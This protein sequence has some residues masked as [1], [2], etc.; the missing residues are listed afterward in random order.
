VTLH[1]H[2]ADGV[3]VLTASRRLAHA[4]RI[5]YATHARQQGMTAW[6][7]PVVLPWTT[8][9]RQQWLDFRARDPAA[10]PTRLLSPAQARLLWEQILA[11][12]P[13]AHDLLNPAEAARTAQRS[14][15]RMH[16]YSIDR[17]AL[18]RFET[19]EARAL[20]AWSQEF[21]R[22]CAAMNAVDEA[23]LAHWA[24]TAELTPAQPLA[25]VGFDLYAPAL[26]RLIAR[27][28][29][30]GLIRS[31][32]QPQAHAAHID[33][34]GA[35]DREAEVELAARWARAQVEAG[36]QSIAVVMADL[37]SRHDEV[38][39]RFEEVFAPT[40]RALN[41]ELAAPPFIIAAP[42]PLSQF[43]IAEGALLFLQLLQGHANSRLAGRLL[44]SPF[45]HAAQQERDARALADARLR[46]EQRDRWDV[47]EFERWAAVTQCK[48]LEL[49]AREVVRLHR[50][51]P[52]RAA[53]SAWAERFHAL[54]RAIGWPGERTL[55]SVEQQTMVKFQAC[56]AEL[57]SLD[58]VVGKVA[59]ADALHELVRLAID[60]LFEPETP[61]AWVTLIDPTTIA[62]MSFDALW[63]AGLDAARLPA[64]SNPDPLI[65]VELQRAAGIPEASA[66]T[67]FA[68]SRRRLQRLLTSANAVVLSWPQTEGDA[69]LQMSPL[70]ADLPQSTIEQVP[71]ADTRPWQRAMFDS[72]P[73]LERAVDDLAPAFAE[74]SARGGARILELQSQCAFRAQAVLRL[75]AQPLERVTS[76]IKASDRGILLH[77][78]LAALWRELGDQQR[79]LAFSPAALEQRLHE[80]AQL[81]AAQAIPAT[82]RPRA[83]LAQL[84]ITNVVQQILRLLE[85]DRRRPPFVIRR[86]ERDE[87]YTIGG[88]ELRLQLDRI[89]QLADGCFVI[90]YKLGDSHQP[91]Q[92]LDTFPGRPRQPQLPLY[93]LA[94]AEELTGLAF[95]ILAPGSVGYRGW[96]NG[97]TVAPGIYG[98]PTGMRRTQDMPG[99]WTLLVQ[100]WREVLN[101]LAQQYV[102]GDAAVDP[103]PQA[104]TYCHLST[105]CR[106]HERAPADEDAELVDD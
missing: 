55:S 81:Q 101:G 28:D 38:Q 8:W 42:Q 23:Q 47:Y 69:E 35:Q 75:S 84:E 90:D 36:R 77:R 56:L 89:D 93:A 16:E 58:A 39:R 53:P 7:T 22:R 34:V 40:S 20:A 63:V 82:T 5:S 52:S 41:G 4:L 80:I 68:F 1:Q 102:A 67:S 79:L 98:Y 12:H 78:V 87:T 70:L 100:H 30:H 96:S 88:L 46:E 11:S 19:L 14:W 59:L 61:A 76:G 24:W 72:R 10:S 6:R 94:H 3:T 44:R 66:E 51:L 31:I 95:A 25:L 64:P 33:V 29:E 32:A 62:G 74:R 27:W 103:L 15:R 92:W 86:A 50:E 91:R 45:L 17:Q 97:V 26:Q 106:I 13:L 105:F 43:P 71:L 73:T 2:L 60:T 83:R 99:D 65:P 54:L 21:E 104:C 48:A 49:A 85:I 18:S 9:L 37:P 57:G